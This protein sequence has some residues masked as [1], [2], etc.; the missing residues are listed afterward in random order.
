MKLSNF[1]NKRLAKEVGEIGQGFAH[2]IF[3][4]YQN[5]H[6]EV[7]IIPVNMCNRVGKMIHHVIASDQ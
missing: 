3:A 7:K 4:V 5:A 6:P 2:E 1:S